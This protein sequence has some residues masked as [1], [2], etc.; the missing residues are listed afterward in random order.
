MFNR[1]DAS[2]AELIFHEL[3]HQQMYVKGDSRFNEAFASAIGEQGAIDWL[4]LYGSEELLATYKKRLLVREDFLSLINEAKRSL[5][6]IY[7][8]DTAETIKRE[9]K[10]HV[11]LG[12]Y[13]KYL[14]LKAEKWNDVGWYDRW[15]NEPINNARLVSIAT[16]RDLV[17]DFNQLFFRCDRDYSRFYSAVEK[18]ASTKNR[19][20]D[21]DCQ[22]KP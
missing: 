19:N 5:S 13:D 14:Q 18:V 6:E 11:F 12:L 16:Y 9:K 8:A 17:P 3:A 1:D 15:F 22:V 10:H 4:Q 2:L 7:N 21:I 20:L